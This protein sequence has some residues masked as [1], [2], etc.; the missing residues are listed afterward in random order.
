MIAAV[1]VVAVVVVAVEVFAFSSQIREKTPC[2][3]NL[4]SDP[5]CATI[6]ADH[7]K[8]LRLWSFQKEA[9]RKRETKKKTKKKK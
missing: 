2:L 7:S 8:L 3:R 4:S 6:D 1:A 5:I 9:R